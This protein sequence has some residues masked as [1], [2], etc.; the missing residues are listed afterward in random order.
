[1]GSTPRSSSKIPYVDVHRTQQTPDVKHWLHKCKTTLINVPGGT[2]SRVQ[3]LDVS[4]KKPF[5]NDVRELF[6]QNLD[7][8]LELYVIGKPTTG[9]RRVLTTKWGDEAWKRVKKQK[10]L[11]KHLFKKCGVRMPLLTSR[12]PNDIKCPCSKRSSR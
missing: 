12:A 6:E 10:D 7:A 5:K 1:M 4:I 3:P 8:D 9:K 2:R 11:I